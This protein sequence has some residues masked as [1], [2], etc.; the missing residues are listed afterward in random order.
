M[1]IQDSYQ[2]SGHL[3]LIRP[4]PK[5]I[6]GLLCKFT[7]HCKNKQALSWRIFQDKNQRNKHAVIFWII[8]QLV[9]LYAYWRI[10]CRIKCVQYILKNISQI[11][12]AFWHFEIFTIKMGSEISEFVYLNKFCIM[13]FFN[14]AEIY[15]YER[16]DE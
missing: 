8:I 10:V 2:F 7:T 1:L 4:P 14:L 13:I 5:P 9:I 11:T 12:H 16:I 3:N 6:E 15:K